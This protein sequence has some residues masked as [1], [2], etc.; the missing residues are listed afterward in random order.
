MLNA[1]NSIHE[2]ARNLKAGNRG[3]PRPSLLTR[4]VLTVVSGVK[5]SSTLSKTGAVTVGHMVGMTKNT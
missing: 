5:Y 1:E 2:P 4:S 3:N